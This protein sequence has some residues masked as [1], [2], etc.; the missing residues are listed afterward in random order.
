[1]IHGATGSMDAWDMEFCAR[2]AAAGRQVIRYDHRDTGESVSYPPGRPGYTMRDLAQDA[3][4]LLDAFGI[5]R[6]HLVGCSMGGG[7]AMLAALEHPARV[8]SLTLV[9]TSPGGPGLPPMSRAFLD[10]IERTGPDWSDRAAV[11]EHVI[12]LLR[13]FSGPSRHFDEA[14]LR[15]EIPLALARTT[16]VASSQ[17]NH[18]AMDAGPPLRHRLGEIAAPAL[19]IHGES[20]PVFPLGHAEALAREIPGAQLLV[21]EGAGHELP[22]AHFDLVIEHLARHTRGRSARTPRSS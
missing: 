12:G 8:D 21:L 13:I 9:G 6:A 22:P 17:I 20:D 16:N 7:L 18:F 4:G 1:L 10:Y 5:A 3:L 19:V 15:R 2:L 11:L 14:K